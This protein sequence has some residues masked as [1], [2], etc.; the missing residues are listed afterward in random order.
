MLVSSFLSSVTLSESFSC[1]KP[2]PLNVKKRYIHLPCTTVTKTTSENPRKLSLGSFMHQGPLHPRYKPQII[3]T[4]RPTNCLADVGVFDGFGW[5]LI[6]EQ[7]S[8][9]W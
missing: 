6:A 8:D 4:N 3:E 1:L 9:T 7:S 5:R 2:L